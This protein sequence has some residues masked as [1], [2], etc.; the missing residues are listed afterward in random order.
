VTNSIFPEEVA[1]DVVRVGNEA[2][3]LGAAH[4]R[5]G[6]HFVEVVH[7]FSLGQRRNLLRPTTIQVDAAQSPA[8]E[9]RAGVRE[10]EQTLPA[11]RLCHQNLLTRLSPKCQSPDEQ[12]ELDL[13]NHV[14]LIR[15][16]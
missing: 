15:S 13:V 12:G 5:L 10:P 2:L 9:R 6:G 4:E 16:R 1:T 14:K 3:D 7:H 8:V 11:S